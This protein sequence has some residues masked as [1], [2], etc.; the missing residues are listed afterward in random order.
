[1]EYD[2]KYILGQLDILEYNLD[3]HRE[4]SQDNINYIRHIID[5]LTEKPKLILAADDECIALELEV[6]DAQRH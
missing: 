1:M 4:Q 3:R 6:D 2:Y 5:E